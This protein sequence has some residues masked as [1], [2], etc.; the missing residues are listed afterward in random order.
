MTLY[1]R[2]GANSNKYSMF[3]FY[4]DAILQILLQTKTLSPGERTLTI[5]R[6]WKKDDVGLDFFN[7]TYPRDE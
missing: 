3:S 5:S 2:L 4:R 1:S 6:K 7:A